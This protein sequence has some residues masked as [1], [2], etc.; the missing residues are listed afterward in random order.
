MLKRIQSIKPPCYIASPS[1]GATKEH[2]HYNS[3]DWKLRRKRIA[4]RDAYICQACK[5]VAYGRSGHCDH[6]VPLEEGGTD[7][8]DNLRWLCDRC[9]GR[10]TRG[11]QRR[12]G[13]L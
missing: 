12:R 4:V 7:D 8:D 1:K 2:A 5:R 6:I 9:H 10:K 3:K 13:V 11:E